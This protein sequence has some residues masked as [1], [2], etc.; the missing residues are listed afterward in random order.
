M[1]PRR[2]QPVMAEIRYDTVYMR[3]GWDLATPTLELYP[4]VLRDVQNFEVSSVVAGGY[5][6]IAGYERFDG[7]TSPSGASFALLQLA[8]YDN[9]PT[10]GQTLT[11]FTSGA[12]G[13]I[14]AIASTYLI[15]TKVTG[16]FSNTEV[17]KV[18]ATTIATLVPTT[19]I[20]SALLTAQYTQLA[21]D[22]Y[23]ADIGAVP[24]SGPIRGVVAGTFGG[25]D[26]V[27]AFRDNA[28]GT[29]V[30]LY[31]SSTGGWVQVP[32]FYEVSFTAG[33]A[34]TP[35]DGATLTQ[36]GVTAT[37]K[38]VMQQSGSWSGSTAAGR[39]IIE[40]PSGGN[41]AAGAATAGAVGVTL[42]GIQT[43][44]TLTPGGKFEFDIENF[45]GQAATRRIYGCDGVN[46]G[47]EFDGTTLAPITTG[48]SPD[49]PLHVKVHKLH[50]F[51]SFASSVIHSGLG[52]PYKWTAVDGAS[53]LA[54]G[55]LVTNLLNQPGTTTTAALG[56]TTRT[57]TLILYGTGVSNW[58]LVP[59][60]VG[61]GGI[62]Y[63][64]QLLN[65]SYWLDGA[66]VVDMRT[67]QNYGN[68]RQA[69][70]TQAI[71]DYILTQRGKVNYSV[72]NRSKN[73]YRILFNDGSALLLTL[74]N[75]KLAGITKALY[76]HTMNCAWSSSTVG[77]NE[78]VFYGASSG[79]YVYQADMG[80]SFDGGAIDAF[81]IFN[82]NSM[83]SPRVHKRFRRASLEMQSSHYAN[84]SFGYSLGYGSPEIPQPTPESYDSGFSSAPVWDSF[85]WDSFTWDGVTLI[86][87]E[88]RMVGTAENVQ[89]AIR[90][91]TNYIQPYVLNSMIFHYSFRRGI[92]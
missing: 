12:T 46:R 11:G 21:A 25:V 80:S 89:I 27:Y 3:G 64:S 6:R 66:G 2:A 22:N 81:L 78:R 57:N 1:P 19:T 53:E 76:G 5:A 34:G 24:G 26:T 79:G 51:F 17:V 54:T 15:V 88:V 86:P 65:E 67:T 62:P 23:R 8:T 56:I 14:I 35:A 59:F 29:A 55:D 28:G 63:S 39:F 48:A 73:Q 41:F 44:I 32:F 10:V 68:F 4:G 31:K 69:T 83:K 70:I 49:T 92:R 52:F 71:Q 7:R 16:A 18:G 50:L 77:L 61:I 38:R 87:S 58:N 37:I 13:V 91:G 90:S 82:W 9:V 74:V 42:S 45:S 20:L 33:G 75:G 30:D 43:A 40:A 60:N 36:G 72:L 47:F 84:F 85:I